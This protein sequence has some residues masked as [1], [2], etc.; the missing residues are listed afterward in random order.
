MYFNFNSSEDHHSLEKLLEKKQWSSHCNCKLE[1]K[2]TA[3]LCQVQDYFFILI[4]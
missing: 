1:I 2:M 3:H 4:I